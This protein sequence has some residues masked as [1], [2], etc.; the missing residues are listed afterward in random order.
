MRSKSVCSHG[1]RMFC[2][3]VIRQ[4][5]TVERG[6][7]C[8]K[9][10]Q[11]KCLFFPVHSTLFSPLLV[12][13]KVTCNMNMQ[14][15]RFVLGCVWFCCDHYLKKKKPFY[16]NFAFYD[17][18][19]PKGFPPW[20]VLVVFPK[21]SQLGQ[22]RDTQPTVHAGCFSVSIIPRTL[23]WTAGS[24]TCT[25]KLMHAIALGGIRTQYENLHWK[26]TLGEK[27]MPCRTGDSNLRRQ[28]SGPM[29]YQ[30]RATSPP[31]TTVSVDWTVI[32]NQSIK[33][34][35][36]CRQLDVEQFNR[37]FFLLGSVHATES[38]PNNDDFA[39]ILDS[40]HWR[41]TADW[42]TNTHRVLQRYWV[43]V[44]WQQ[45]EISFSRWI[46]NRQ[47]NLTPNLG[48]CCVRCYGAV[49]VWSFSLLTQG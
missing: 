3:I 48:L 33:S 9:F 27:K 1:N 25:H 34:F 43:Q 46:F 2:P 13:D 18:I 38:S 22:S 28:R 36:P 24:I 16:F 15:F 21:E 30:L 29:L 23:T 41:N 12:R 44:L 14:S 37:F 26:L 42:C 10:Y 19:V 39:F 35:N 11:S 49:C 32:S 5:L 7:Y 31:I 17:C 47:R 20:E 40:L 8:P 4:C 6:L 45:A